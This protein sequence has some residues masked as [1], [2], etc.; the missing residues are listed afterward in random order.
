MTWQSEQELTAENMEFV[1]FCIE[2]VAEYLNRDTVEVYDLLT[3]DR[4]VL[5]HYIIPNCDVLHTQGK[6]YI[7]EDIIDT[8]QE[9]GLI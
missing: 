6:D 7:V 1:I 4:N 3:S 9:W 2:N 5:Y 8:M